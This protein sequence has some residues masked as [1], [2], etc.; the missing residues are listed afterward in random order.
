MKK[1]LVPSKVL[2]T[3]ML[4]ADTATRVKNVEK[5]QGLIDKLDKNKDLVPSTPVP[6]A[7]VP[8]GIRRS[9]RILESNE[10]LQ[11]S[12]LVIAST[13]VFTEDELA[14]IANMDDNSVNEDINMEGQ[15]GQSS[16]VDLSGT[17]L[18]LSND[19]NVRSNNPSYE[20]SPTKL[21]EYSTFKSDGLWEIFDK[22]VFDHILKDWTT[23]KSKRKI[24]I[25][26]PINFVIPGGD[27]AIIRWSERYSKDETSFRKPNSVVVVK[28]G[29]FEFCGCER[30]C[31][32]QNVAG[33]SHF[34]GYCLKRMHA[35]CFAFPCTWGVCRN[36]FNIQNNQKST[37]KVFVRKEPLRPP[38]S[39]STTIQKKKEM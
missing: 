21:K 27:E 19:K 33:S 11:N 32:S 7:N 16:S 38:I 12:T 34:C 20:L 23:M 39:L 6:T 15:Q 1:S 10:Q 30:V 36:C 31:C 14:L 13:Q 18:D 29:L 24:N 4:A 17:V 3:T 35:L 28:H 37:K 22:A 8:A 5:S 25:D 2:H 9:P 26:R